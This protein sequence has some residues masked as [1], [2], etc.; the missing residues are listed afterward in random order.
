MICKLK[1]LGDDGDVDLDADG[2]FSRSHEM[3]RDEVDDVKSL[4]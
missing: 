2:I 3:R 1:I 4:K